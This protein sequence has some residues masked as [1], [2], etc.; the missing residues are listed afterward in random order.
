MK[1]TKGEILGK[2]CRNYKKRIVYEENVFNA[3]DEYAK[4]ESA[5]LLEVLIKAKEIIKTW[6]TINL[7][8]S[9]EA[10][11]FWQIYNIT[12]PEMKPINEVIKKA[13]S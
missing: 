3:M 9:P 2:H 6:H 5:E 4:Q 8:M 7:G 1:H 13:T 11:K 10:D 12:S